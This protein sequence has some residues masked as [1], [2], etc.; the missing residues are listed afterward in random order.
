MSGR[1]VLLEYLSDELLVSFA[2]EDILSFN[3]QVR[4][5]FS[6]VKSIDDFGSGL[7]VT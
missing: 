5:F 6:S 1:I 2:I 7:Q 3:S 4:P